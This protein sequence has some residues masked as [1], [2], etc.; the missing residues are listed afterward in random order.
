MRHPACMSAREKP[1]GLT[2][3]VFCVYSA[4]S[5]QAGGGLGNDKNKAKIPRIIPDPKPSPPS[6]QRSITRPL[7]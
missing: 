1:V 6:T 4:P 2:K 5:D 7:Y 3:A